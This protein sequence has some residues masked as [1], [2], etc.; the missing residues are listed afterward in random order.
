MPGAAFQQ[1]TGFP[2]FQDFGST[3]NAVSR[4]GALRKQ[5]KQSLWWDYGGFN[6]FGMF[7]CKS[8]NVHGTEHGEEV[9]ECFGR[10]EGMSKSNRDV[11]ENI[12]KKSCN[13]TLKKFIGIFQCWNGVIYQGGMSVWHAEWQ[14]WGH[15]GIFTVALRVWAGPWPKACDW[16]WCFSSCI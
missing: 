10:E 14:Q 5:A 12:N 9:S 16:R 11:K 3:T 15:W 13:M 7:S 1:R 6:T 4:A 8:W 2:K